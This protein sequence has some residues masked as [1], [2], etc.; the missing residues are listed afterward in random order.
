MGSD[1]SNLQSSDNKNIDNH[2]CQ[3]LQKSKLNNYNWVPSFVSL[4]GNNGNDGNETNDHIDNVDNKQ[5]QYIDLRRNMPIIDEGDSEEKHTQVVKAFSLVINYELLISKK[6]YTFPPSYRYLDYL[7]KNVIGT[8][9]LHSFSHVSHVIR[10]FGICAESDY[11]NYPERPCDITFHRANAFR[12]MRFNRLDVNLDILKT[13]LTKDKPL[14]LGLPI[15]SNF[16]KTESHPKLSLTNE[17][18]ILLGGL[19]G[20]IIGYQ[21][22]DQHFIV[23]TS[24]G[25]RWGER[26]DIFIPYAYLLEKGAEIVSVEI[27][28]ELVLLD[29]ERE[30]HSSLVE[31][32]PISTRGDNGHGNGNGNDNDHEHN[33]CLKTVF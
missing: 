3:F 33:N 12:H 11:T 7:L 19:V 8:Y 2:N 32:P 25:R 16:L 10:K 24:K 30:K 15:Y 27:I 26:G 4:K 17:D 13:Y 23:R 28:E 29:L 18:D 22:A 1:Q 20:V 21:E 9:Q 6:L 31:E 5:A 14:I